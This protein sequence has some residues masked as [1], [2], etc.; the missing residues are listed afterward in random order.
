MKVLL[1]LSGGMDSTTLLGLELH[2]GNDVSLVHFQYGSKHNPYEQKAVESIVFHYQ[3]QYGI[4]IP[5]ITVDLTKITGHLQSNLLTSGGKIPEG[6][7]Q[8]SNMSQTVVPGRN[9]MFLSVCASI[10]ESRGINAVIIGA[11][12]GDHVI[13]PDCRPAFIEAAAEAI[14]YSTEGKVTVLAPFLHGDKTALIKAGLPIGV[15]YHLTRTCYKDQRISCGVCGACQERL[16]GFANNG[17]DDPIEYE[18]RKMLP[19]PTH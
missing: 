13:Y 4:I 7:Y 1:S 10:A 11:H 6:H 9:L 18:S 8:Q 19:K 14:K 2:K 15:P 12:S 3:H 17:V 16:E 5:R